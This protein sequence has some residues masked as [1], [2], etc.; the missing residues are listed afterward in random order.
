MGLLWMHDGT[1][2]IYL[3]KYMFL[4]QP[5][6]LPTLHIG[7]NTPADL[8]G[9]HGMCAKTIALYFYSAEWDWLEF[10][11]PKHRVA[12]LAFVYHQCSLSYVHYVPADI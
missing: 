4:P 8:C 5:I 6:C 12:N 2:S 7:F 10:I 9:M 11:Y 3:N 1:I